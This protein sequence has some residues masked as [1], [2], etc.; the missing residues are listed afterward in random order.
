MVKEGEGNEDE[1]VMMKGMKII[2]GKG[3]MDDRLR[4][5]VKKSFEIKIFEEVIIIEMEGVKK[6]FMEIKK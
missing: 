6:V 2:I 1:M 4:M 5:K 3:V